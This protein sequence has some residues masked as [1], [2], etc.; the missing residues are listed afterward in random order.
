MASSSEKKFLM[1]DYLQLIHETEKLTERMELI[2]N[3]IPEKKYIEQFYLTIHREYPTL[4]VKD[5]IEMFS[6]IYEK[7]T[8]QY[9]SDYLI[10][11]DKYHFLCQELNNNQQLVNIYMHIRDFI[12]QNQ[13]I[14]NDVKNSLIDKMCIIMANKLQN[15]A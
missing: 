12:Y 10:L 15:Y 9:I 1:I 8:I 13:K 5:L 7:E 2:Y 3:K 14:N 6:V 11:K 4:A